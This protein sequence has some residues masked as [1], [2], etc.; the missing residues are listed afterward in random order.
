[1]RFLSHKLQKLIKKHTP[2]IF[3][4]FTFFIILIMP[5]LLTQSNFTEKLNFSNTGQIGDTIGGITTP[6]ISLI[7]TIIV[8]YALTTQINNNQSNQK[9]ILEQNSADHLNNLYSFLN[10]SINNFK[11]KSLPKEHLRNIDEFDIENEKCGGEA[12]FK[13]FSQIFCNYHSDQNNLNSNQSVNELL[14]ILN[15]FI[16]ILEELKNTESK[17]K[18]TIQIL[19]SHLF[20]YKI[21]TRL[22]LEYENL[23]RTFCDECNYDHGLPDDLRLLILTIKN[24]IEMF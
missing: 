9:Q 13:L 3:L 16:I 12:V 23:E 7:N 22:K 8:Y 1:M 11:F 18:K 2:I 6:L 4:C 24:E 14:S 17:N 21:E 15:I 19:T 5:F 10:N 20:K